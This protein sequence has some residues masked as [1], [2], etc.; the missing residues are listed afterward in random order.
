[1]FSLSKGVG[2]TRFDYRSSYYQLQQLM[3]TN[4]RVV[5]AKIQGK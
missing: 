4:G 1:M 3:R 5:Q 2:Q